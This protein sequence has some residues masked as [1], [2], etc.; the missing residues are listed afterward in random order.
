[1]ADSPR[2]PR[3]QVFRPL[4]GYRALCA[5]AGPVAELC[6]RVGPPR[7]PKLPSCFQAVCGSIVSQ[8]L[9]GKAADTIFG[10]F[11]ALFA[12]PLTPAKVLRTPV[13]RLRQA[14]LS[15]AKALAV[16]DLARKVEAG[17]VDF[18]E[19]PRL[20]DDE[21]IARLVQVRGIGT[22]TAQMHLIFALSRTD[23]WPID[24]LGVRKGMARFLD[25]PMTASR[26]HRERAGE[27]YRPWRSLLAWYFWR[28]VALPEE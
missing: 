19:L 18:D 10:R 16:H 25:V 1:M 11:L 17:V 15:Q 6:R 9:S 4:R 12:P 26:E 27:P 20:S 8:Q 28:G 14:G 23:V 3:T 2:L 7:L 13:P 22:W 5:M 24:D 21:V